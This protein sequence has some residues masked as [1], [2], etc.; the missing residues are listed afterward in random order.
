MKIQ[1]IL[2]AFAALLSV[3]T[4]MAKPTPENNL[5]G[6]AKNA[7]Q[8]NRQLST[9]G[10]LASL[11]DANENSTL[12]NSLAA[13]ERNLRA[14]VSVAESANDKGMGHLLPNENVKLTRLLTGVQN[15]LHRFALY[16]KPVVDELERETGQTKS[17]NVIRIGQPTITQRLSR[18]GVIEPGLLANEA[19]ALIVGLGRDPLTGETVSSRGVLSASQLAA[20]MRTLHQEFSVLAGEFLVATSDLIRGAQSEAVIY[21][22]ISDAGPRTSALY[23]ELLRTFNSLNKAVDGFSENGQSMPQMYRYFSEGEINLDRQPLLDPASAKQ[24]QNNVLFDLRVNIE[25]LKKQLPNWFLE[26]LRAPRQ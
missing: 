12:S 11:V 9:A 8:M 5:K 24:A 23:R 18:A 15:E 17:L 21:S 16:M 2:L 25:F 4:A 14:A 20:S 19:N 7:S 1:N 26:S 6:A 3:E 10:A 22:I 13:V